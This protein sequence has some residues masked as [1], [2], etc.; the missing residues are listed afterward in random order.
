M[1][2]HCFIEMF[3]KKTFFFC[4]LHPSSKYDTPIF[5][6][7]QNGCHWCYFFRTV[8]GNEKKKK[9]ARV[10]CHKFLLLSTRA[11]G[12]NKNNI[13]IIFDF[14]VHRRNF[15]NRMNKKSFLMQPHS[16]RERNHCTIVIN[17]VLNCLNSDI[18]ATQLYV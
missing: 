12:R 15:K 5:R 13:L 10:S 9:T 6:C 14:R 18:R 17:S 1:M 3:R 8:R 11:I 2:L 16:K 7:T 4:N